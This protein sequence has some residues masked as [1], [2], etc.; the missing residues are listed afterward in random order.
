[1]A[2]EPK[3]KPNAASVEAF[4]D[5][6][7]HAGRREDGKWIAA[8]MAEVSGEEPVMWGP[9]IV[10]YGTCRMK[11]GDWP[12]IGFSPRKANLVLYLSSDFEGYGD[13]MARLGKH[14]TSVACLYINRMADVDPAVLRELT[15]E[16]VKAARA[17]YPS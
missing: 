16:S 14:R 12:V 11:T 6:V 2:Y 4:L 9:S 13:L 15:V 3:T 5:T 8:M 7:P 10:G 1:M 17:K